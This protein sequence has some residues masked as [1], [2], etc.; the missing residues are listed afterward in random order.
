MSTATLT[1]TLRPML[2]SDADAVAEIFREA[3]LVGT[4]A[5][6]T[7]EQRIAWAGP[8]LDPE[9]WRDR[10]GISVG[11]IAERGGKPVGCMTLMEGNHLDMAF[12]RPEATGTGVGGL[13]LSSLTMI[14]RAGGARAITSDVSITARPFFERYGFKVVKDQVRIR[15]GVELPNFAMRKDL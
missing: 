2:P 4:A 10:I 5:D 12:V 11:L 6:Y 8:K 15:R 7:E 14:A 1:A 9:R 3:I 13:L